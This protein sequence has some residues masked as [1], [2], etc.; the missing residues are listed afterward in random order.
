M[1]LIALK[2]TI[3]TA[4]ENRAML[5]ESAVQDQIRQ[6]IELLDKGQVRVAEPSA[7]AGKWR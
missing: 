7:E 1:D 3:E 6:L 4:W 5:K 2:Q